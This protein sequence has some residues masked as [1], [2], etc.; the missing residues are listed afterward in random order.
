MFSPFFT[1]FLSYQDFGYRS[2]P[3][4]P[5]LIQYLIK[6]CLFS[7]SVFFINVKADIFINKLE[8]GRTC[9]KNYLKKTLFYIYIF[10]TY[11]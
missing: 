4:I 11:K 8:P 9:K 10:N 2:G 7:K 1:N 6:T 3:I 5:N